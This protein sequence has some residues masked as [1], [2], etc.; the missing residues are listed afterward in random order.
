MRLIEHQ[1]TIY[2]DSSYAG[3]N[4]FSVNL[5][6]GMYST[7]GT[8]VFPEVDY[9][10]GSGYNQTTGVFTAP[11]DGYYLFHGELV[12]HTSSAY[13]YLMVNGVDKHRGYLHTSYGFNAATLGG[14]FKLSVGDS[15]S[16]FLTSDDTLYCYG[17]SCHFDGF[18]L[19]EII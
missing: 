19:H 17:D 12:G 2:S 10:Q 18:L 16:L 4:G 1:L 13:V 8:I 5:P 3:L 15:V 14:I 7:G 6:E 9:I 11:I